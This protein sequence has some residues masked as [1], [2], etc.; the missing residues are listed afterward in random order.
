MNIPLAHENAENFRRTAV[1]TAARMLEKQPDLANHYLLKPI[2]EPFTLFMESSISEERFRPE[3]E[4]VNEAILQQCLVNLEMIISA[5]S[6][7]NT[8]AQAVKEGM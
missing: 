3:E 2:L 8:L 4:V 7:N 1:E 5:S 6:V